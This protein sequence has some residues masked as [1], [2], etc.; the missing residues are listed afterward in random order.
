MPLA[1]GTDGA[2]THQP[3]Q[4]VRLVLIVLGGLAITGLS[5]FLIRRAMRSRR[6]LDDD[7]WA[8]TML[9]Q[10]EHDGQLY[11]HPRPANQTVLAYAGALAERTFPDPE[12]ESVGRILNAELYA[13]SSDPGDRTI[14]ESIVKRASAAAAAELKQRRRSRRRA[15]LAAV[16]PRSWPGRFR[17]SSRR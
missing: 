16:N 10:L 15:T 11:H 1:A 13:P 4:T 6:R 12:L 9:R 8:V 5:A 3:S 14:A 7:V 2:S 17:R